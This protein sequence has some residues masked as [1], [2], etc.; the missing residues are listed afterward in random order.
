[1]FPGRPGETY[2]P[3]NYRVTRI[4]RS[5]SF[6]VSISQACKEKSDIGAYPANAGS[7]FMFCYNVY[8][9][10]VPCHLNVRE[11]PRSYSSLSR[12][13]SARTYA[14]I[15]VECTRHIPTAETEKHERT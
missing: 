10:I 1:M 5:F 2:L 15:S 12:G 4:D 3:I 9:V 13:N 8:P 7:P 6:R 11:T 14:A